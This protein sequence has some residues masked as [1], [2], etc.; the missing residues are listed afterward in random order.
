VNHSQI[1]VGVMAYNEEGNI[2]LLLESL[3]N[4]SIDDQITRIIVV[5][6]G[7]TDR[8]CEIVAEYCRRDSRVE[9]VAE[10]ERA[11][12]IAAINQ[13]MGM[14]T[15]PLVVVSCGDL[16]FERTTIESLC[17]PFAD[18][19]VGMTGA[20]PMPVNSG[21]DFAAFAVQ[22]MWE[23][24]HR[25]AM[26]EPK[27]GELVA[28]RN[29]LS[30]LDPRALCDEI[31]IETQIR[32]AGLEVAYTPDA[33]VRNQGPQTVREFFRQ[34]CRWIAANYQV[35][36]DYDA[37]V[38]TMKP[39][40]V[41]AATRAYLRDARAPLHWIA[42]VACI[43]IAARAKAFI[44]YHLLK[45]RQQYRVWAPIES[46]KVLAESGKDGEREHIAV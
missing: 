20:H 4:Q 37:S 17:R 23:L 40:L 18:R 3:L 8:T 26:H 9:L 22:L 46:T 36:S 15:E 28:F 13:F 30:P 33:T 42:A 16:I 41:L 31:S 1:A 6:S 12:K 34:R 27:M 44:D 24:H 29:V 2:A 45:S 35:M 14:V 10:P 38:S 11:G 21:R 5:A 43:E 7:C 25:V 39:G 32:A 19:R